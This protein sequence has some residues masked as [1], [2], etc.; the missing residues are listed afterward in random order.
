[1]G[2]GLERRRIFDT[3][4]DKRDFPAR[5][6]EEPF[7]YTAPR[8]FLDME[9]L[10]ARPLPEA[11]LAKAIEE[12]AEEKKEKDEALKNSMSLTI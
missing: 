6:S 1:M 5:L 11:A 12:K 9:E 4:E 2:R 8:T 3:V 10:K 7:A